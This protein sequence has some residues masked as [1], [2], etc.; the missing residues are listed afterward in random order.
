[1]TGL[2]AAVA[3]FAVTATITDDREALAERVAALV[4]DTVGVAIAGS[5]LPAFRILV[6]ALHPLP[7]GPC[8]VYGSGIRTDMQTAALLN[9]F[10]A[11]VL[12]YD[13][14]SERAYTH[15]SA[16][17]VPVIAAAGDARDLTQGAVIEAYAVAYQVEHA[18]A[19]TLPIRSAYARGWHASGLIGPLTAAVAASRLLGLSEEQTSAALGLATARAGG[20]LA[21]FGAMAKPLTV[22]QSASDGLSSAVLARR[23][24]TAGDDPLGGAGGLLDMFGRRADAA[25][26]A[27][28]LELP[29]ALRTHGP[30]LKPY[31]ACSAAR[32]AID[33]ARR[34]RIDPGMIES[35]SVVVEPGGLDALVHP[36]PQTPDQ[37]RFSLPALVSL[38]LVDHDVT[39]ESFSPEALAR[40]L[41]QRLAARVTADTSATPPTGVRDWHDAYA[42]VTATTTDGRT[43][44]ERA[45][46]PRGA[47]WPWP[48]IRRKFDLC[49]G[50][51]PDAAA[52]WESARSLGEPTRWNERFRLHPRP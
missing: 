43:I 4:A 46:A 29:W 19:A 20:S 2:T 16:T 41:V 44:R 9:G 10:A 3:H 52:W 37:A 42:V 45:D 23:G 28:G 27:A 5:R 11:H 50:P 49:A 15:P 33:A 21:N 12:D 38:A 1:M 40:P 39:V 34:L 32:C 48:D 7:A 26:V 24:V 51:D 8:Q 6:D 14:V 47:L 30:D 31:P 17:L 18:L 25:Q 36:D 35:V 22:A 13:D